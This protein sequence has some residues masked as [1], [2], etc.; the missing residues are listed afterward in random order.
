M[1]S[2][3]AAGRNGPAPLERLQQSLQTH[4]GEECHHKT[5]GTT[6]QLQTSSSSF[7]GADDT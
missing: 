3:S 5:R 6:H 1:T 4:D 2:A 7:T